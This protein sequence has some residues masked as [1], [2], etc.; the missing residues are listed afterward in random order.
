MLRLAPLA[1]V[2]LLGFA[3]TNVD[4]DTPAPAPGNETE[5]ETTPEGAKENTTEAAETTDASDDAPDFTDPQSDAMNA[6]A[7]DT[8]DAHFTTTAGDFTIRVT[9][10]WAPQG[11]DR[12]YNLVRSGYFDDQR[13]FRVVPGFV[14]QW[15]I[16]GDPA[17]SEKWRGQQIKDDPIQPDVP[18]TTGRVVFAN[19]GPDTRTT[20]LFINLADNKAL[21]D[22]RRMKGSVFAP[23]GEI[24]EGMETVQ[25]LHSGYGEAP[26]QRQGN[27][28]T[29]GNDFLDALFPKLDR[30]ESA[31]ILEPE[32]ET[33]QE[34]PTTQPA[35]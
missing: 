28:Q 30:I 11:A 17:V 7:P 13:F 34:T 5:S 23:F 21:D 8:F 22:P 14:V 15:G 33:T 25:A 19:A 27:I 29:N 3:C 31:T 35:E 9:R 32:E 26:S 6:T 24:I 10:Q 20:Q 16:H 12:F 18:N 4:A 2:I 1:A